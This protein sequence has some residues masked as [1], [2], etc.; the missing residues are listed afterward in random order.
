MA[1]HA[2][3]NSPRYEVQN[4]TLGADRTVKLRSKFRGQSQTPFALAIETFLT[5][6]NAMLDEFALKADMLTNEMETGGHISL[7]QFEA[8]WTSVQTWLLSSIKEVR[9]QESVAERAAKRPGHRLQ[10]RLELPET[11]LTDVLRRLDKVRHRI[12]CMLLNASVEAATGLRKLHSSCTT[13]R[14]QILEN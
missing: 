9:A 14:Q 7:T 2:L 3:H 11:T 8:R 10:N 5:S 6:A 1:A 4:Q 13:L 12:D